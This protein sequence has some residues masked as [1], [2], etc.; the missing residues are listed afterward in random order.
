MLRNVHASGCS[1][2]CE[3][4]TTSNRAG[5]TKIPWQLRKCTKARGAVPGV[6]LPLSWMDRISWVA[7][8]Q[9]SSLWS[10]NCALQVDFEE[11]AE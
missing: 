4:I 8:A 9:V 2:L 6:R 1:T 10:E 7:I 3:Q 11:S 5:T